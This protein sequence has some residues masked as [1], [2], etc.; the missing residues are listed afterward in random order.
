MAIF[1]RLLTNQE[2][3]CFHLQCVD[4]SIFYRE[5]CSVYVAEHEPAV[6]FSDHY[7]FTLNLSIMKTARSD[8]L[9][10]CVFVCR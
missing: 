3:Q 7:L 4:E 1:P 8:W 6:D 5:L 2:L 10:F 9:R